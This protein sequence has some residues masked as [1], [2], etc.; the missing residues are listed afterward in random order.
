[1]VTV[2]E[3]PTHNACTRVKSQESVKTRLLKTNRRGDRGQ[4]AAVLQE[5]ELLELVRHF[6][7]EEGLVEAMRCVEKA[8]QSSQKGQ[9]LVFLR[10]LVLNG[11]WNDVIKYLSPL[12]TLNGYLAC[13]YQLY[14]QEYLE[15]LT[16]KEK[17]DDLE[18]KL[19]KMLTRLKSITSCEEEFSSLLFLL[20]VPDPTIHCEKWTRM[21]GRLALFHHISDFLTC[22]LVTPTLKRNQRKHRLAQLVTKGLLYERCETVCSARHGITLPE[23]DRLLNLYEWIEQQPASSFMS[24]PG[25][26]QIATLAHSTKMARKIVPAAPTNLMSSSMVVPGV[27]EEQKE[28]E[29]TVL[30]CS[31]PQSIHWTR[32]ISAREPTVHITNQL[33]STDIRVRSI[34]FNKQF[35]TLLSQQPLV[36]FTPEILPLPPGKKSDFSTPKA[37]QRET[38]P[39]QPISSPVPYYTGTHGTPYV[40][41]CPQEERDAQTQFPKATL[42]S[43]ITDPQVLILATIL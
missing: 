35:H 20:T 10:E 30:S 31:A 41:K 36:D 2:V 6:L 13:C 25:S 34:I 43:M 29:P 5:K 40:R 4:M 23:D 37:N 26:M 18:A 17:I 21:G 12:K 11:Q 28:A 33:N 19:C 3:M 9:E 24:P 14:K 15:L 8:S 7:E 27:D 38:P 39:L 22:H 42:A 1:M 32:S 16:S